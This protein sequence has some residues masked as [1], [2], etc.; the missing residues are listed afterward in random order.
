MGGAAKCDS[1][2]VPVVQ[3]NGKRGLQRFGPDGI[4]RGAGN[5]VFLSATLEVEAVATAENGA[6]GLW[7]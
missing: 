4:V 2:G 5:R 7:F 1:S 6:T 3:P